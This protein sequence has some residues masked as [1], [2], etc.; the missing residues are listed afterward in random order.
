MAEFFQVL[1]MMAMPVAILLMIRHRIVRQNQI[2]Q[3][4]NQPPAAMGRW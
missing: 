4:P 3:P 1:T 2:A